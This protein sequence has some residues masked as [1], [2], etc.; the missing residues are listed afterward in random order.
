MTI[1][2]ALIQPPVIGI[3]KFIGDISSGWRNRKW[4]TS[5]RFVGDVLY[6]NT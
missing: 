3:K 4:E 6:N 5:K 2:A 1:L